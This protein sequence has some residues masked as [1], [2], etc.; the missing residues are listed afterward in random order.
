MVTL[1]S[2]AHSPETLGCEFEK[3]LAALKEIG[4]DEYVIYRNRRP[5]PIKI[6]L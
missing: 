3:T 6:D 5:E 1:G 2:D 4:F